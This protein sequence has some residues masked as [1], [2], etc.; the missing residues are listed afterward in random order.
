[1]N[2]TIRAEHAAI[3]REG[4]ESLPAALAII[5]ELAGVGGHALNGLMAAL[6]AGKRRF[7]LHEGLVA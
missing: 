2:R 1:M 3:A 4:L 5:K 6:R 7:Q